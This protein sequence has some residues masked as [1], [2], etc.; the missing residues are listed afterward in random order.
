[1]HPTWKASKHYALIFMHCLLK[2][3]SD[4][5]A[6]HRVLKKEERRL[7]SRGGPAIQVGPEDVAFGSVSGLPPACR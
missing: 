3:W 2:S 7:Q 1:M 4:T 6:L 5:G